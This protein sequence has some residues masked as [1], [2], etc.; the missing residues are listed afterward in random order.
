MAGDHSIG[1]EPWNPPVPP[2]E[3]ARFVSNYDRGYRDGYEAAKRELEAQLGKVGEFALNN[4]TH[5][6]GDIAR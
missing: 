5:I 1:E 2:S 3:P 4:V 6:R